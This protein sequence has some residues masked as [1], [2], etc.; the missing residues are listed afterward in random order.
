M[1]LRIGTPPVPIRDVRRRVIEPAPMSEEEMACRRILMVRHG[2]YERTGGLGDLQWGLSPL[3][4]RQAVKVGKRLTQVVTA[5]AGRFEGLYSSPWPRATQTAEIAAHEMEIDSVSIKPYL[6]EVVPLVDSSRLD[7]SVFPTGL[8]ATPTE[9]REAAHGQVERV[10]GRFFKAPKRASIVVLI[11]H[12]NMI[13][14]LVARV[15]RLPYESWAVMDIAHCGVTELR[16]FPS[17]FEALIA[18]NETGHF[19]PSMIT[20]A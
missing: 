15:L 8:D 1:G 16:V 4:R 9:E 11:T 18:F 7:L 10:R 6:H 14:Y 2:H 19:P 12:G 5:A 13:R 3:G 17:G 20:T